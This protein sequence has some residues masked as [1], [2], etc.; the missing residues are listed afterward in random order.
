VIK[1]ETRQ[2]LEFHL[3]DYQENLKFRYLFP[4]AETIAQRF[5]QAIV[6]QLQAYSTD[7]GMLAERLG[8][9][10]VDRESAAAVLD[11]MHACGRKISEGLARLKAGLSGAANADA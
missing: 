9:Q 10:Q 2:S 5:E 6:Q 4:L 8:T 3:K 11:D 1:R 7:F